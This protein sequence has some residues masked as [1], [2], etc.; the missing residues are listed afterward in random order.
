[1]LN[2]FFGHTSVTF[3][4]QIVVVMQMNL[5][6]GKEIIITFQESSMVCP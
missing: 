5:V 4:I 1:M 3:H 6:S 2:G